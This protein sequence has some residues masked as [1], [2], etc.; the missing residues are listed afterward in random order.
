MPGS[1]TDAGPLV[2][3][4]AVTGKIASAVRDCWANTLNPAADEA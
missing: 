1:A 3:G 2:G 4:T